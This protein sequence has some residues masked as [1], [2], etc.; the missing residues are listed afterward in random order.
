LSLNNYF[1]E[2]KRILQID[3]IPEHLPDSVDSLILIPHRDLHR[4]PLHI[5]FPEKYT[6][7]YLPSVQIGLR[8]RSGDSSYS[9]LLSVEDPETAQ[10][11][12]V[13]ARLE[14]VIISHLVKPSERISPENASLENVRKAL[15][16]AHKTFHFTGHGYYD[17]IRPE[18]S[19]IALSDGLLTVRDIGALN[20]SS[21]RLVCLAACETAL[22]GKDGITTEYVGLVSAFL[23]AGAGNV[24][25]TLWPVDEI[26]SAWF[27]IYFYQRLLAG[28]SPSQALKNTQNWLKNLTWQ[29]LADWI[30]SFPALGYR[31]QQELETM[32]EEIRGKM[33]TDSPYGSPFFWAVFTVG[34]RNEL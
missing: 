16:N 17:S 20:L 19:A 27:M 13:Y 4:F 9:P 24:L 33:G 3:K 22:T 30:A 5:L 26:S 6:A 25:S 32:I 18:A 15:E 34:G 10:P 7:I 21:Y 8:P 1:A 31:W 29:Q 12:M 28:E 14:S 2:L 11:G 23:K